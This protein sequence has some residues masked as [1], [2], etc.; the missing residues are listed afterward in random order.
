MLFISMGF[1]KT[2]FITINVDSAYIPDM[3]SL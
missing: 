2:A 3:L 1:V